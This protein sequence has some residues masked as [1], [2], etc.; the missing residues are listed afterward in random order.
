MEQAYAGYEDLALRSELVALSW[1]DFAYL[2]KAVNCFSLSDV[3]PIRTLSNAAQAS[4]I[5]SSASIPRYLQI[6]LFRAI[7]ENRLHVY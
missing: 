5:F 2:Y 6:D 1:E 4:Q 7:Y 3:P